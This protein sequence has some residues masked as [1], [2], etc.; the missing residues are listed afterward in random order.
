MPQAIIHFHAASIGETKCALRIINALNVQRYWENKAILFTYT[1]KYAEAYLIKEG[2]TF[3]FCHVSRISLRESWCKLGETSYTKKVLVIL[4]KDRINKLIKFYKQNG[5]I[6]LNL[7]AKPPQSLKSAIYEK[8]IAKSLTK[9]DRFTCENDEMRSGILSYNCNAKVDITGTLKAPDSIGDVKSLQGTRNI[10]YVSVRNHEVAVLAHIINSLKTVDVP[11]RHIIIPRYIKSSW[12][13]HK[14]INSFHKGINKRLRGVIMAGNYAEFTRCIDT[15]DLGI[16]VYHGLGDVERILNMSHVAV[17]CGTLCNGIISKS[18][19]HNV[20]EPLS[21]NIPTII[22]PN[23]DNW[24]SSIRMLKQEHLI[25]ECGPQEIPTKIKEIIRSPIDYTI[26]SKN[27]RSSITLEYQRA[28]CDRIIQ[29]LV[30]CIG[31]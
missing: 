5:G 6:V 1:S 28:A 8:Y 15:I 2:A 29:V 4:E 3:E 26:I 22:G 19:G 21:L 30:D 9:I 7:E 20:Y 31:L 25:Y 18:K 27:I 23:Y 24:A 12:L 16:L 14:D 10:V 11:L 17:V 13:R